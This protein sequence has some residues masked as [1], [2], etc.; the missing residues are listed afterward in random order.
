MSNHVVFGTA[1][2]TDI[3]VTFWSPTAINVNVPSLSDGVYPVQVMANE[4]DSNMV[5]FTVGSGGVGSKDYILRSTAN[6]NLNWIAFPYTNS[7]YNTTT[8]L[9]AAIGNTIPIGSR[10][11]WV[12]VVEVNVWDASNQSQTTYQVWWDGSI[13]N[14]LGSST[15]LAVGNMYTIAIP[16]VADGNVFTISGGIPSGGSVSFT[17]RNVSNGNVSWI[18]TPAY[19]TGIA[20]TTDLATS[21]GN[22]IP[23][24]SRTAWVDVV[25]VNVWDA[26]NQSQTTYQVWWD[27]STWN[28]LG[29]N[30]TVV[31]PGPYKVTVPSSANGNIWP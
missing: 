14:D 17:L 1:K 8:D 13:W 23:I 21:I 26:S 30:T 6:G 18:T 2:V 5:D 4:K 7:G 25:E 10:T 20:T 12:D 28:D 22:T 15:S 11:A 9:A 24:G 27:G 31:T 16:S 19:L 3:N 29:S